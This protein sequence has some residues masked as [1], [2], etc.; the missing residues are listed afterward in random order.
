MCCSRRRDVAKSFHITRQSSPSTPSRY[1]IP[2][3]T[4]VNM[5]AI[6]RLLR[7]QHREKCLGLT[8]DKP[9]L[10]RDIPII[11]VIK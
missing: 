4:G 9:S 7:D 1:N 2:G 3:L 5:R 8:R 10:A 11:S 6:T